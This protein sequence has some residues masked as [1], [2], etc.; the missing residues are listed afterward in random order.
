MRNDFFYFIEV[1]LFSMCCLVLIKN[2]YS[3]AQIMWT[4]DG[5]FQLSMM[6]KIIFSASISYIIAILITGF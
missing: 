2:L 4:K 6:G 3:I 5:K 1:F